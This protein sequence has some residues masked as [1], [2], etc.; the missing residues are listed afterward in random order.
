MEQLRSVRAPVIGTLLN[1]VD[2]ARESRYDPAYRYYE[3]Q[4]YAPAG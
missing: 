4:L 3:H 1:D 2:V